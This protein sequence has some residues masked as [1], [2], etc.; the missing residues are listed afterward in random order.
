MN[1]SDAFTDWPVF[2]LWPSKLE[3]QELV[4]SP[5]HSTIV[6]FPF[7]MHMNSAPETEFFQKEPSHGTQSI[8]FEMYSW[9]LQPT[10]FIA[11]GVVDDATHCAE[12]KLES[13]LHNTPVA[14]LPQSSSSSPQHLPL[15]F[16]SVPDK[17]EHA[18]SD[19]SGSVSSGTDGLAPEGQT[20]PPDMHFVSPR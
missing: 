16:Q 15:A 6:F 2:N 18:P 10:Y 4:S 12:M 13:I 9:F 3:M 5:Q 7:P 8:P 11:P 19:P 17:Q 14:V 1:E 20:H